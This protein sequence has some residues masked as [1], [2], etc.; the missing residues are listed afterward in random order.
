MSNFKSTQ[1]LYQFTNF[2]KNADKLSNKRLEVGYFDEPHPSG[3]NMATLAAIHEEGWHNLPV[4]NFMLSSALNACYDQYI[5]RKLRNIIS[6]IISGNGYTPP[7]N[8]LGIALQ[9]RM[10]K[11]IQ[12]GDFSNPTVSAEW[13]AKKGSDKAL[14]NFGDLYNSTKYR[15]I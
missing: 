1:D 12:L 3:L 2:K 8:A 15:L 5:I 11:T 13:A 4:R 14:I 9:N 6:S 10:K 7:L